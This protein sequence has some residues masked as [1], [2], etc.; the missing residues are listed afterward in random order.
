MYNLADPAQRALAYGGFSP[1]QL[2]GISQ[3]TSGYQYTPAYFAAGGRALTQR[4]EGNTVLSDNADYADSQ[5]LL[6]F[7]DVES[8]RLANTLVKGQ[9]LLD[10]IET[11][12]LSTYG[13]AI[14]TNQLVLET[15]LTAE[16]R[17]DLL[18]GMNLTYGVSARYTDA[19]MLQDFFD[20]PFGRR[21][22]TQAQISANTVILSGPQRGPDGKNFWSPTAQGG[23]NAHSKLWQLS[24]F[25]YSENKFTD[26][27]TTYASILLAQAPYDTEYPSEVDLVGPNDPRRTPVSADKSY[28][29][30]SF[31]PV[32]KVVEG[33]NLYATAQRGTALDPLQGG[34]I[35]NEN[36]F[37]QNKL[38]EG[39]VKTS[40]L[41]GTL[42]TSLAVYKWEQ[43]RFDD[44]TTAA[45][46]LEGRGTE[47]E[48]TYA[49][50][51][52]FSL[53]GSLNRQRVERKSPLGFRTMPLTEQQWALYGG[54][55]NSQFGPAAFNPSAGAR[56]AANPDL[57]YPGT[58]ETQAKLY[59]IYTFPCGFG[60]S[61]GPI[62]SDDYW[63]N[64]DRTIRIDSRIVWNGALFYR[65]S[66]YEITLSV[67]NI[68]NEDYFLGA[69]P[70]F[71]ANTLIT[72][73]P[74]LNA[75]LAV[76]LKF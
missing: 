6:Y 16:H 59:A 51:K 14:S 27:F 12:K 47:F 40:L 20:E 60:V 37:S 44:R 63:H 10:Y 28:T 57:V 21:D 13:Y 52:T 5:N 43:T 66:A 70:V 41:A 61:G 68:T 2:A 75:K 36:N 50:T 30:L 26:R 72:K 25:A 23:A 49:P 22:I 18:A 32:F 56:P 64:F 48:F 35:V 46:P 11:D 17:L 42:F 67:E 9:F 1:A 15:K 55:L 38:Y 65:A 69:E 33:V 8:T 53:I 62:W 73:A 3:S 24:A 34:A 58:P 31:S 4:I 39:G 29:S 54:V 19:K 45:E 74:E 7:F 71:G 76:T